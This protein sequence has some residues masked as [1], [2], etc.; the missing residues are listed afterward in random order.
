M[1]ILRAFTKH[2]AEGKSPAELLFICHASSEE[3]LL[4]P[5]DQTNRN[6]VH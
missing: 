2:D 1:C 5:V 3:L 4:L 6:S